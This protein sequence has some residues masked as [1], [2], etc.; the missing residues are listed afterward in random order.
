MIKFCLGQS[1]LLIGVMFIDCGR[2]YPK[3]KTFIEKH[4]QSYQHRSYF[5]NYKGVV[6]VALGATTIS[7]LT[8]N[9]DKS[10]FYAKPELEL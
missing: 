9:Y 10:I 8:S 5:C 1:R 4:V 6:F 2:D 7:K 3:I